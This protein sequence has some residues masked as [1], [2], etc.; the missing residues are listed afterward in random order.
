MQAS[1]LIA[2]AIIQTGKLVTELAELYMRNETERFDPKKAR[3]EI[4]RI[5]NERK[6]DEA[7]ERRAFERAR[8]ERNG[9]RA[10]APG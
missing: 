10:K 3:D 8:A 4:K 2:L 6:L 9:Q 5:T 1:E 7:I